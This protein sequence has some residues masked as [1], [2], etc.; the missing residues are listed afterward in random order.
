[1]TIGIIV[2]EI[3]I[4]KATSTGTIEEA[5]EEEEA[6]IIGVATKVA[7]IIETITIEDITLT[8]TTITMTRTIAKY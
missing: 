2:I 7:I 4:I 1:M 3:T 8:I 6:V 5:V